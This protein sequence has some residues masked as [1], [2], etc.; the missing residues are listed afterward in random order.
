MSEIAEGWILAPLG[1]VATTQLGRMLSARRETGAHAKPYLRN[2]D[3]Q[4]GHINTKDLP[5]MDFTPKDSE[6]FLLRPGDVL[7]CEGGEVG[8][9]AIWNGQ[10][11]ECYY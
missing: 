11:A 3:V 5:M 10:L 2:R 9:A 8:R 6:R 7:I 1:K 4:W